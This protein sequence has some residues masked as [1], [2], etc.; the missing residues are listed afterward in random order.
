[1]RFDLDLVFYQTVHRLMEYSLPAG[2]SFAHRMSQAAQLPVMNM[3][4][5]PIAYVQLLVLSLETLM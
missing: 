2:N 3:S 5:T 1:M 4:A